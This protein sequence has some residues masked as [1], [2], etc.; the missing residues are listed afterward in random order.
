[1]TG[2]GRSRGGLALCFFLAAT[3]AF[4][5]AIFYDAPHFGI[6]GTL[7]FFVGR[8]FASP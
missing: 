2:K 3:A 8:A 5:V 7:L 4:L 1:M 6:Y